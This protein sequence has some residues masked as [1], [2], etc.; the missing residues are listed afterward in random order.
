MTT[1]STSSWPLKRWLTIIAWTLA[2]VLTLAA[3]LT[4]VA[5]V[6]LTGQTGRDVVEQLLDD[7]TIS[8]YGRLQAS[9]LSGNI[10]DDLSIETLTLEDEDGVWLEI[11][12]LRL[13]WSVLPALSRQIEI[14]TLTAGEVIIY[15]RPVLS[16]P[17][18]SSPAPRFQLT[19]SQ[20]GLEQIDL[21]EAVPGG[22]AL[23]TASGNL[24]RQNRDWSFDLDVIRTDQPGDELFLSGQLGRQLE[25]DA[26]L[27]ASGEGP[28]TALLGISGA[29]LSVTSEVSG[30]RNGGDGQMIAV[31]GNRELASGTINWDETAARLN[32]QLDAEPW[33]GLD[34]VKTILN[35]PASL[36][37]GLPL[38]PGPQVRFQ[39]D[40]LTL[41][42]E[43]PGLTAAVQRLD[44]NRFDISLSRAGPVLG[45]LTGDQV[46]SR[47]LL[48]DG[49]L[50]RSDGLLV[51]GVV[52]ANELSLPQI[53][54]SDARGNISLEGPL[55]ALQI[56][57]QMT[58][59][60]TRYEL[61]Q[62]NDWLGTSPQLSLDMTY[63]SEDQRLDFA[64]LDVDGTILSLS[65]SG[66]YDI[67]AQS[68][69]TSATLSDFPL[70]ELDERLTGLADIDAN[71]DG[72]FSGPVAFEFSTLTD[73][74]QGALLDS[75]GAEARLT[76]QGRWTGGRNVQLSAL[77][78][79]SPLA[80]ATGEGTISDA[81]WS[82]AGQ[83]LWSGTVPV[84]AIEMTGQAQ[85]DL[86]ASANAGELFVRTQLH[87]GSLAAGNIT[88]NEPLVRLELGGDMND[89]AGEW[90][91][92]AN[93]Q[94]E[95][96]DL[97]GQI[98]RNDTGLALDEIRGQAMGYVLEG[99]LQ[100]GEAANSFRLAASPQSGF[101]RVIFTGEITDSNID[102]RADGED[103]ITGDLNYLDQFSLRAMGT[104]SQ[105]DIE[106]EAEG[107]YGA[108]FQIA[109]TGQATLED[110]FS[111]N[112]LPSG[113]YGQTEIQTL[114]PVQVRRDDTGLFVD[115][116][117]GMDEGD[118]TLSYSSLDA[119]RDY[120]S[121]NL[122][123]D[124]VPAALLSYRRNRAPAEGLISGTGQFFLN[125]AG[126]NGE[127]DL[128]GEGLKP[129]GDDDDPAVDGRVTVRL[130]DTQLAM[131][132]TVESTALQG[133]ANLDI[134]TGPVTSVAM[135][136]RG[137]NALTGRL[138]I[139][140]EISPLTAFHIDENR[141]ING[142]MN[143]SARLSGQVGTPELSG[144]LALSD[145]QFRDDSIGM[146]LTAISADAQFNNDGLTLTQLSG[147]DLSGGRFDGAGSISL[148]ASN[149]AAEATLNFNSLQVAQR[150]E[151][152][153]TASGDLILALDNNRLNVTGAAEIE[154]AEIR[155]PDARAQ[156]IIEIAVEE[157]NV[158]G[159]QRRD[160]EG[161]AA[162]TLDIQLDYAI[163]APARI[164]VRGPQFDTE[165]AL[166]MRAS[167]SPSD[168]T[169]RGNATLVRGRADLLGR[170]FMFQDGRISFAGDP[171]D[172]RLNITATRQARDIE[173]R[174]RVTGTARSPRIQ[175]TSNPSL[176][177]DEIA[178]RIL[179]D[180]GAANLSGLQAAQMAAALS[181]FAGGVDPF[182][183][184]RS[185][186][187][188]DQLSVGSNSEGQTVVSGGRYLTEEVYLE[189]EGTS[190][191]AA[192]TTRI[193][194]FLGRGL[195]FGSEVTGTGDGAISLSW[196][197]QY[198]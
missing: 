150:E 130:N 166:D 198:D 5:V 16:P 9:G 59:N 63:L 134:L 17:Q 11:H 128:Q 124:R 32:A 197:T 107:A 167:G 183:A 125:P 56:S 143:A 68:F 176:P 77:S 64:R 60:G 99:Q 80:T 173:A 148:N 191:G 159:D 48:F 8:R 45:L 139:A 7:R 62:L 91:L 87:T 116:R 10:L 92:T 113:R 83:A 98:A 131:T 162:N 137:E 184:V 29:S 85:I 160:R 169:L 50:N 39:L 61:A 14:E 90:R 21:R 177:Q 156:P 41:D 24:I 103:L 40:Q 44:Q 84:A 15:R 53:T 2:I 18:P 67:Q 72:Q 28:I 165:W 46:T 23:L 3:A 110:G 190:G 126:W 33:P 36:E 193:E 102:I 26:R 65:A 25:L 96:V 142:Q 145:G 74:L 158:P 31:I 155:P 149:L 133:N 120:P 101:G 121:I 136:T 1:S 79:Q 22:P 141:R 82:A 168:I 164:F 129:A 144:S 42:L 51:T 27:D 95:T 196:R 153:A 13:D 109:L 34:T 78:L 12:D 112:L 47:D 157:I 94:G 117:L 115:A 181:S 174:L 54:L 151:L 106:G 180:Q 127:L 58:T 73:Q 86:E 88:L 114:D 195:T 19:I 38:A 123:L 132:A 20:L 66:Q 122:E 6:I 119:E 52:N 43:S 187:G 75:L 175:L 49:E 93:E 111:I 71:A 69:Q 108:R 81:G 178:A 135:M 140:G 194:W 186:T 154:R 89:L 57:A 76:G 138:D 189:L 171:M 163:T 172:S 179:F 100:S 147:R 170:P 70:S 152:T 161:Q 182:A 30:D 188:L 118:L 97:S 4:G 185:A 146:R 192:P 55:S 104:P 105:V 35:G 37:L